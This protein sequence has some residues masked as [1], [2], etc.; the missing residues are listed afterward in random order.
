MRLSIKNFRS[1]DSSEFIFEKNKIILIDG[2]SGSGKSTI[3]N[4]IYWCLYGSMQ[5]IFNNNKDKL[6]VEIEFGNL[7]IT[8]KKKPDILIVE[9]DDKKY[10][11]DVAQ[12][13]II[14][15]FGS[16]ELWLAS[17]YLKQGERNNLL[18]STNSEKLK[19][20]EE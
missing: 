5:H 17:C 19:L 14:H 12:E 1:H 18:C 13:I 20:I 6:S 9:I 8:R 2:V 4:S 16:K 3:F 11:D 15:Y 7:K 10:E